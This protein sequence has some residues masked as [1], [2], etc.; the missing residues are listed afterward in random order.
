MAKKLGR[1]PKPV[2]PDPPP[3]MQCLQIINY[4]NGRQ[5][6]APFSSVWLAQR[7]LEQWFKNFMEQGSIFSFVIVCADGTIL[8]AYIFERPDEKD[9]LGEWQHRGAK[10][11]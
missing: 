6:S 5:E 11:R 1:P 9:M 8:L 7:S 2:E 10:V 3:V 4:R